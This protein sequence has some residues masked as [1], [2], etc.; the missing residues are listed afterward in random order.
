MTEPLTFYT[1]EACPRCSQG[2]VLVYH[3]GGPCPKEA[4]QNAQSWQCCV[5]GVV[6][7]VWVDR[8]VL[9]YQNAQS[10]HCCAFRW[11]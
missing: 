2:E 7:P 10:W 3:Y 5:C 11:R 6:Y 9:C 4:L 8:C 1:G